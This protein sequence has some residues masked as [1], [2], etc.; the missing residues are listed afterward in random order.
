MILVAGTARH[1]S[2]RATTV[3]VPR[4]TL[5]DEVSSVVNILE[6]VAHGVVD[7]CSPDADDLMKAVIVEAVFKLDAILAFEEA[8]AAAFN[9]LDLTDEPF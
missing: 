5:H 2:E 7:T 9:D 4:I 3:Y 1:E 8:L 6:I